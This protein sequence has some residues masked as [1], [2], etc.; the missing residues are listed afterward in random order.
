MTRAQDPGSEI[1]VLVLYTHDAVAGAD[2]DLHS[3]IQI[4]V[5][6]TNDSFI[7][8]GIQTTLKM[9]PLWA[10]EVD[11]QESGDDDTDVSA[12][13]NNTF[14]RDLRDFVAADLVV[15]Y[16]HNLDKCG[17]SDNVVGSFAVVKARVGCMEKHTFAH[18]VGH[19][20][21]AE[22]DWYHYT[23]P[24]PGDG[25]AEPESWESASD[26]HGYIQI[27]SW[28][29]GGAIRT[30]MAEH[31]GCDHLGIT[32]DRILRWSKP[33][34]FSQNG[35]PLGIWKGLPRPAND[36]RVLN[37]NRHD[38]ANKRHSA[39]RYLPGC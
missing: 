33:D 3:Q 25:F 38:V 19:N 16:V 6:H 21:G 2:F 28:E 17:A 14:I 35:L 20:M 24:S 15:L 4:G 5:D 29:Q 1:E 31:T 18:E 8:S 39:C 36:S 32:C 22:H 9:V 37:A 11:F 13:M 10:L 7:A 30:I 34:D 26:A 27:A 12:L 23:S